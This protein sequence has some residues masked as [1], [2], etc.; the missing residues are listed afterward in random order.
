[1]AR[2]SDAE[3]AA[4]AEKM[5]LLLADITSMLAGVQATANKKP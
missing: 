2:A 4:L 3:R 1:M 5:H